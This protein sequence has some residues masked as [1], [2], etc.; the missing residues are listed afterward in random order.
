M[1]KTSL[2]IATAIILTTSGIIWYRAA[3]TIITA[4]EL[5]TVIVGTNAE[6]PPFSFKENDTMTGFDID[7]ITVVLT[8]LNKKMIFKDMPFEAL[9]PEIQLGNIH[10]IA[11]GITPTKERA[12]RALFTRPHLAAGNPLIIISLSEL[13]LT[14]L[15]D[16]TGKTI[17]VN[18]GY[19]ADSYI[20]EQSGIHIL[21]LSSAAVSDGM[22]ALESDRADAFVTAAF[23]MKPYFD[24]YSAKN[25]SV[26]PI[27]A[28]EETSAFAVSKHY[29]ELRDYMQVTLDRMQEDGTLDTLKRKWNLL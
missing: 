5:D 14:A 8:R 23:S 3:K 4:T 21:R 9:L 10:V 18:E 25:F 2:Y 15:D 6:F 24:K 28:T 7:V 13:P 19:V 26:A 16:L 12:K 17:V 20:S 22:L 1:N 11:A 29:R 27:P